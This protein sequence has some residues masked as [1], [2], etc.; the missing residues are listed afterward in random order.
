MIPV[1]TDLD[2]VHTLRGFLDHFRATLRRQADGLDAAAL[3]VTLAPSD[4][5]LGGLLAHMAFVEQWWFGEILHGSAPHERWAGVDWGADNDHD[6]HVAAGRQPEELRAWFDEAVADADVRLDE[7][8]APGQGC[9][10]VAVAPSRSGAPMT[11]R[12]ILVHMVEEYA[13][14][15]GHADLIRQSIDGATDL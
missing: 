5:S 2:E 10:A 7:A 3:G 4:V 13:R 15:C 6:W 9:E 1:A 12:W 11:V 8:L 14:H